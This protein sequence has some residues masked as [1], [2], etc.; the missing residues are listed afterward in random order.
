VAGEEPARSPVDNL[1]YQVNLAA[2]A[3]RALLDA[4]L[5][6]QGITFATWVVLNVLA[7]R[8][9]QIQRDLAG[10][11][12]V[13]GPTMVRRLDQLEA[14]GLVTRGPVPGDRRATRISLTS[15]G[16]ALYQRI[17]DAVRE[18][19]ADLLAALD[20]QEVATTRRVL[21]QVVERARAL[22]QR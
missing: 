11:V 17:R 5:A 18:T 3:T 4:R 2:R 21:R 6:E 19:E 22:R 8:G 20:P 10:S 16:Q 1:G 14:A 9:A 12:D 13:E 7:T 15:E